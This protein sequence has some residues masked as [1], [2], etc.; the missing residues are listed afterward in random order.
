MD[1]GAL[2]FERGLL[3]RAGPIVVFRMVAIKLLTTLLS[4]S[5]NIFPTI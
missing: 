3:H 5:F 2:H 4:I 1:L